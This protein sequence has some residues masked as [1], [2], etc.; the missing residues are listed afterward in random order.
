MHKLGQP[1]GQQTY[2]AL[3]MPSWHF[4]THYSSSLGC[5]DEEKLDIRQLAIPKAGM[6]NEDQAPVLKLPL[7]QQFK[8]AASHKRYL[9]NHEA[10]AGSLSGPQQQGR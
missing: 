5:F 8:L 9:D 6:E 4:M 1:L 2:R 10:A 7:K 3:A